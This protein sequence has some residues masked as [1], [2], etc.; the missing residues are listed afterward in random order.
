MTE[1]EIVKVM[2]VSRTIVREAIKGLEALELIEPK[3]GEGLF[4][5]EFKI[6]PLLGYLSYQILF[7]KESLRDMLTIRRALETYFIRDVIKQ[8]KPDNIKELEVIVE[9]MKE[10]DN[11]TREDDVKLDL[12][13][14][15]SLY[16]GLNNVIM[17][18][19][20]TVFWGLIYKYTS[21]KA[22]G[23]LTEMHE[24][25]LEA[26]KEKDKEGAYQMMINHYTILE[27]LEEVI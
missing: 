25:L 21:A 26:I 18:K 7:D 11:G 9:H 16:R 1:G 17:E 15:L 14:H 20:I 3:R 2:G 22:R 6:Q 23:R 24:P 13:F 8:I 27:E 5:K 19:F 4:V 12:E 10:C